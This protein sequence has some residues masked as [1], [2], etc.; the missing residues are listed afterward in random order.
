MGALSGFRLVQMRETTPVD[1]AAFLLAELGMDVIHVTQPQPPIGRGRSVEDAAHNVTGRNKRSIRL[2]LRSEAGRNAFYRLIRTAD[3]LVESNRPGGA[4][5]LGIDYDTIRSIAPSIVYCSLSGHG[6]TGPYA[7]LFT[8]DPEACAA[9]G[10]TATNVDGDGQAVPFG[11]LLG[12]GSSA[13]H[14][15]LAIQAALLHRERTGQGQFID[16]SM[17]ACM[18][19]YQLSYAA[20]YLR[21]GTS[22]HE[23]LAMAS[24]FRCADDKYVS[25]T[26]PTP[27]RW[28]T[29][30]Q[31]VGLPE[32]GGRPSYP[33]WSDLD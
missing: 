19:T 30:C 2:D 8:Y 21:D 31:A 24:L 17:A 4:K 26:N 33:G 16:V 14:A 25:S 18:L 10:A 32:H 9:G 20:D 29:F 12:D 13:L 1:T 22:H 6:Q 23:N 11:V 28:A 5:R 27:E 7:D 15:A 3:V